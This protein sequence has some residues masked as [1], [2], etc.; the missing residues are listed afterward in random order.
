MEFSYDS[1]PERCILA[2]PALLQSDI[3]LGYEHPRIWPRVYHS[4]HANH[5]VP[6]GGSVF[7]ASSA[8]EATWS[9]SNIH[10]EPQLHLPVGSQEWF[11]ESNH[12]ADSP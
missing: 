5:T 2:L 1:V 3:V 4:A 7:W 10:S 12:N 11:K 6:G 9:R 8:R